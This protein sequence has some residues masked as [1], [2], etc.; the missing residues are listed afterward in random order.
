VIYLAETVPAA[1]VG[2]LEDKGATVVRHGAD[3]DAAMAAAKRVAR[4]NGWFLLSDSSWPGYAEPARDVMEGYLIMA[5]EAAEQI[6]EPPTHIF[7][8]A[9]VGGLAAACTV[10]ARSFWGDR[11]TI[12]IVE[13][14]RAP[15]LFES[16]REG[17]PVHA[18]GPDSNMGRLDCKEPS[19]LAL[20]LLAREADAF[21]TITDEEA[22]AAV[23]TLARHQTA[24]SP[25]GG[26]GVAG[27][28]RIG[29]SRDVI[30]LDQTSRVLAYVSEGPVDAGT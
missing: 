9:G 13:P 22:E 10:A 28:L 6:A 15:A 14:D 11:P 5:A 20:A 19:H 26:A 21:M 17:R 12:V 8:Q 3:Y 23:K 25:S 29:G 27:L 24:T 1:F 7:L 4:E 2:K 18:G 30:G 16:I